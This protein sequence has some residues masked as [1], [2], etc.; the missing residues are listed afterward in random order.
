MNKGSV[1][2]FFEDFSVGQE[3][4]CPTPRI[5]THADRVAYIALTGDR[6][7][8]FCDSQ[9]LVHPLIVL[10]TVLGQTV[11]QISLN[12][13]ANLGYAEMLWGK[14]VCV[15]DEIR[16][17][18]RVIGLKENSNQKTGI[19]YVKTIGVNQRD[20]MVLE[21]VRWVMVK[22]NRESATPSLHTPTTPIL[23]S[24]VAA[25]KLPMHSLDQWNPAATGGR[26]YFNDYTVGERIFHIDGMTI[27]S[28]DHMSFTRL[29][30]NS[31][32]VHFD[33]LLTNGKPLVYGG[34]PISIGYAQAFNGLENRM[35]IAAVNS[36]AH[37]N[38]VHAGDTLYS[39]TQVLERAELSGTHGA[40]RLRLVVVKNERPETV[41]SFSI[42]TLDQQ[43]GKE[44]Y[45]PNVV[46][47]LDYW[48]LFAK[49][50]RA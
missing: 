42:K 24:S 46:L 30:Q 6:T 49:A 3:F 15:G 13:Q 31:A 16:T 4:R 41:E 38:P 34:V 50:A 40:L 44:A 21:Y 26:F 28:S 27:N 36:G 8:R 37:A 7:P 5:L 1:T 32:R 14:P 20:E 48:E 19:V 9:G 23:E 10:H 43:S 18:A 2:N 47:D 33:T 29:Y 22:K 11:R 45:R 17:T 35:G 25:D 39:F 12:A